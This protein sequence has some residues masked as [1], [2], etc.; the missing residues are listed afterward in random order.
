MTLCVYQSGLSVILL[1]R[2]LFSEWF[3]TIYICP[4][5][6]IVSCSFIWYLASFL[7]LSLIR[8][9]E[10]LILPKQRMIMSSLDNPSPLS[11]TTPTPSTYLVS[12]H[13]EVIFC[14]LLLYNTIV[15][16]FPSFYS[17]Q[18][19]IG[20]DVGINGVIATY[21]QNDIFTVCLLPFLNIFKLPVTWQI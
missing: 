8:K 3:R 9:K 1:N 19:L 11:G 4:K 2:R 18:K 10:V 12:F 20:F 16:Y 15:V 6:F 5:L 21:L 7:S 14:C 13:S 17:T